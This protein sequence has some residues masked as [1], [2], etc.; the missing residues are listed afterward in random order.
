MDVRKTVIIKES[1]ERQ[2][3]ERRNRVDRIRHRTVAAI[4]RDRAVPGNVGTSGRRS[5]RQA[6]GGCDARHR[7]HRRT[8]HALFRCSSA[9][10]FGPAEGN[11]SIS[12]HVVRC[13]RW[14]CSHQVVEIPVLEGEREP[15][16]GGDPLPIHG[17]S[18]LPAVFEPLDGSTMN[19]GPVLES[20]YHVVKYWPA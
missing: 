17:D 19:V 11:R 3:A 9:G 2:P 5:H 4:A 1:T 8:A 10:D 7:C 18:P 12:T 14:R 13:L 6:P 16:I 15:G 20:L